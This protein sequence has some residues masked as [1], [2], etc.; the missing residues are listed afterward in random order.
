[1][2]KPD[3]VNSWED[4]EKLAAPRLKELGREDTPQLAVSAMDKYELVEALAQVYGLAKPQKA[5]NHDV[6]RQLKQKARVAKKERDGI[7]AQPPGSRDKQKLTS[8]RREIRRLKRKM[9]RQARA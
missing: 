5:K 3:D 4:L 8:T 1:M 9:R 2:P 7:L 6:I